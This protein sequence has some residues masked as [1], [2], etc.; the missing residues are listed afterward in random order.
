MQ[1]VRSSIVTNEQKQFHRNLALTLGLA[2][3]GLILLLLPLSGLLPA[4]VVQD[5]WGFWLPAIVGLGLV[6]GS[7]WFG[8]LVWLYF[9]A[10]RGEEQLYQYLNQFLGQEFIYFRNLTLPGTRSVGAIDGVLLGPHGALVLQIEQ[11]RGEF[12]SEGDTWF[13][14]NGNPNSL[15]AEKKRRRMPDSPTWAAIR[16][17]REVKAWLSVRE[18][19]LVPVHPI[20]VL[21]RGKLRTS[22]RPSCPV[23]E[24]WSIQNFIESNVLQNLPQVVAEPIS[25]G[26][27]EQ[28]AQR[29]QV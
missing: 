23:V 8:R 5:G 3:G 10:G 27:V 9:D 15:D 14:Y 28:I 21:S 25:G 1:I 26:T 19:P 29:L 7:I 18:L 24:L 12:A 16:A 13:R 2:G 22:K 17:G 6:G 4:N 11:S 20:V